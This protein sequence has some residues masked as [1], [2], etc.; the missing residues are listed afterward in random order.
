MLTGLWREH[1]VV[2]IDIIRRRW[3]FFA[4]PF[5]IASCLAFAA[6]KLAPLKYTAESLILLQGANKSR[7][8]TWV[9]QRIA[10]EQR[11]FAAEQVVAMEAWLKSDQVLEELVVDLGEDRGARTRQQLVGAAYALRGALSLELVGSSMLAVRLEGP[12][13]VGLGRKLE[14]IVA[15]LMEGL[16]APE[17]SILSANQFVVVGR[18]EEA[19]NATNAF[20]NAVKAAG[21]ESPDKVRAQLYQLRDVLGKLKG[22]QQ[23]ERDG[24]AQP[25][26]SRQ[27]EIDALVATA[28][29]LRRSISE[30]LATEQNLER[31]FAAEAAARARFDQLKTRV[32]NQL[33]NYVSIFESPENLLVLGRPEDP[34]A[35]ESA[36]KKLAIAGLL[37]SFLGSMGLVFLVEMVA[38]PL[39]TRREFEAASGL[40]VLARIGDLPRARTQP[41]AVPG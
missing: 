22:L 24:E 20:A 38:G 23:A 28:A 37:A 14:M 33:S 36:A 25:A 19:A 41:A 7:S 12:S 3:M 40:P 27:G 31:L 30:D 16:T 34:I 10:T 11:L 6:V 13:P 21:N 32:P 5:F 35:G 1:L 39:R 29:Q 15:R 9:P 26:A 4:I 17:K 2:A 18:Q 8:N